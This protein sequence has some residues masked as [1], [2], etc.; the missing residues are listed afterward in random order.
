[1]SLLLDALQRASKEKEKLAES[2]AAG[3]ES[4]PKAAPEPRDPFP[5]ISLDPVSESKA[6]SVLPELSIEPLPIEPEPLVTKRMATVDPVVATE[7]ETLTSALPESSLLIESPANVI[8]VNVDNSSNA[9]LSPTETHATN[10]DLEILAALAS[11]SQIP[12]NDTHDDSTV[13]QPQQRA[14]IAEKPPLSSVPP[15]Q[16]NP[17]KETRAAEISPEIAREILGVTAKPKFKAKPRT[18]ALAA[19]A[20]AVFVGYGAFWFGAFDHLLGISRSSLTPQNPPPSGAPAMA[21]VAVVEQ[22]PSEAAQPKQDASAKGTTAEANTRPSTEAG[23]EKSIK[24][25]QAVA[26][27]AEVAAEPAR[28]SKRGNSRSAS[29]SLKPVVV[30]RPSEPADLDL[31]YAALGDGRLGDARNFYRKALEKNPAER[32][33]LLGLA[34]IAHREGDNDSARL[35]YQQVLRLDPNNPVATSGLLAIIADGDLA[36]SAARA[37]EFAERAPDSAPALANLGAMLAREGRI[38]EAQQ[39]Y[40]KALT[41]EPDN[42]LHAYNLAVALDK[43]HKYSQAEAFY[44][45]ALKLAEKANAAEK[46]GLPISEARQ[47]LGEIRRGA[48]GRIS[49]PEAT[50]R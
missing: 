43:L 30:A 45:R 50:M 4:P 23:N 15:A 46:A 33:A 34:Y 9:S 28:P 48:A 14:E 16:A 12:A 18:V 37:R 36:Q 7:G 11:S 47:R 40:F 13:Y 49:L 6:G 25:A 10:S 20:V 8:A 35:Q 19:V 31:A 29:P 5:S 42:P 27:G 38:A 17:V 26:S 21:P 1:M 44:E 2:R 24:A 32:D 22:T 39:A 3:R 41:L